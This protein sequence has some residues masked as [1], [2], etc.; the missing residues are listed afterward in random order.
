LYLRIF[1]KLVR[2][3]KGE[4]FGSGNTYLRFDGGEWDVSNF[5]VREP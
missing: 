4:N 5:T 1:C 3:C 2:I